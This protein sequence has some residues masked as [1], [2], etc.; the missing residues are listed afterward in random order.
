MKRRRFLV[1]GGTS[2]LALVA[3]GPSEDP[4]DISVRADTAADQ[5][6]NWAKELSGVGSLGQ[7]WQ[8]QHQD[9]DHMRALLMDLALE[10]DTPLSRDALV[11]LLNRRVEQE[12]AS[13]HRFEHAGWWLAP[14]E[15]RLA[16]LHV[17]LI[18]Y[19]DIEETAPTFE[20]AALGHLLEVESFAPRQ[21]TQGAGLKHPSLPDNVIWFR[22]ADASRQLRVM[23]D[24]TRLTPSFQDAGFSVRLPDELVRRIGNAPGEVDIWF[25]DP[26]RELRQ[27]AGTL[28][29]MA[30]ISEGPCP[31][32]NWGPQ[33][34]PAGEI[35]NP[36]PGGNAA[37][38]VLTPS[39]PPT[40]V[41]TLAGVELPTQ[42]GE[43]VVTALVP[44]PALYQTPGQYPLEIFD[45]ASGKRC[46]IG[47]FVVLPP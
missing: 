22:A 38:W 24:G 32:S 30:V 9:Q 12:L 3:C 36:Q 33:S 29:V 43:G 4:G 11:A 27:K 5:L 8:E 34:T 19:S 16:A 6:R 45:T 26:I 28:R 31:V 47:I 23:I 15:A 1:L 2:C 37:L 17:E 20:S 39:S 35:F 18:G 41:L 7:A 13:G 25:W 14:I 42:V 40:A 10:P 21:M 44:D 46:Q